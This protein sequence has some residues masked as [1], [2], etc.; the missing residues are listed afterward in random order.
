[1]RTVSRDPTQRFTDRVDD[2]VRYRPRYPDA[3][4]TY[5]AQ[6]AELTPESIVADI[7]S[8]T[9]F[10]A[11]VFARH[12]CEV[13]GVEPNAAMRT[14]GEALL[15]AYPRLHSV[16]GTAEATRLP[17][18][19]VD[20]AVAGQALHW[21]NQDTA[22][23]E[24]RRILRPGGRI[25]ICWNERDAEHSGFLREYNALLLR[26]VP[27]Y[28]DVGHRHMGPATYERLFGHDRYRLG[29]FPN[30]QAFD[31]ESLRGRMRSSSYAPKP[32]HPAHTALMADLDA[33]FDRYQQ[34]GQ[35]TFTYVTKV[36]W[37]TIADGT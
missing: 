22:R 27:E 23:A 10:L 3:L 26:Y 13:Y 4:V 8:G 28:K 32:G 12:G 34:D 37:G 24:W 9:G 18:A 11:E 30:A 25:A 1:M 21:F 36:Y 31:R 19:T 6:E 17:P 20:W 14:A 7:G 29:T 15:A 2:Y 5:L 33:L 16:E 35:V